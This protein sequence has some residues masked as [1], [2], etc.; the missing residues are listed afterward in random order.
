MATT[1]KEMRSAQEDPNFLIAPRDE[2]L[3]NKRGVP[4]SFSSAESTEDR[5]YDRLLSEAPTEDLSEDD[6][7]EGFHAD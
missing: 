6:F 1:V 3:E 5:D 4:V 2:D 7:A